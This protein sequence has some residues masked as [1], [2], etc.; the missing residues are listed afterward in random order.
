MIFQLRK[1]NKITET[2]IPFEITSFLKKRKMK[3]IKRK[4]RDAFGV[5]S[6]P[7]LI[8]TII[9]GYSKNFTKLDGY[10]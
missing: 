6:M 8:S 3:E 2:V 5:L 9:F 4:V 10:I 1:T 7:C